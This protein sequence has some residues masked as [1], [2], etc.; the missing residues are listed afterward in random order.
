MPLP[1]PPSLCRLP[2]SLSCRSRTTRGSRMGGGGEDHT[3]LPLWVGMVAALLFFSV[4]YHVDHSCH[5]TPS[6]PGH[7]PWAAIPLSRPAPFPLSED[8]WHRGRGD[9]TVQESLPS[10][11]LAFEI[12]PVRMSE[13][14]LWKLHAYEKGNWCVSSQGDDSETNMALLNWTSWPT[15]REYSSY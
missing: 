15:G 4:W 11:C 2:V 6:G 8:C 3:W 10:S 5:V 12:P 14:Y 1:P 9:L 13:W 7:S